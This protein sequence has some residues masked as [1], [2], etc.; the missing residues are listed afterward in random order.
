MPFNFFFIL[1]KTFSPGKIQKLDF[2]NSNSW[3]TY[4]IVFK[5]RSVEAV[6]TTTILL[7]EGRLVF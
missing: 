5:K 1:F 2:G 4:G 7:F 3:K 6:F